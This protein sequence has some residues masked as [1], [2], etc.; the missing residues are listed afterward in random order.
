MRDERNKDLIDSIGKNTVIHHSVE[1][2]VENKRGDGRGIFIG[3]DCV[4]YPRNRL[5]LGNLGANPNASM[6]IGDHVQINSGGY[7]SGEGGLIIGDYVLIGPN[8]CILSAGHRYDDPTRLIQSQGLTYGSIV[9]E[10]DAWIGGGSVVRQG[11]TIG[12]GAVIGAGTVVW[13]DVP[14]RAVV[15]GNPGRII[16]YRGASRK[17]WRLEMYLWFLKKLK[18]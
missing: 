7:L 6:S 16:K 11:V 8:T 2:L 18:I 4:I 17:R 9:I 12:E 15:V 13:E 10:R 14:P 5:V 3:A 1:V